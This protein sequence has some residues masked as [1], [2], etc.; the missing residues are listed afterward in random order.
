[1]IDWALT[2]PRREASLFT[3]PGPYEARLF[4]VLSNVLGFHRRKLGR[5]AS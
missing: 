4:Y 5:T 1:M 2:S 3:L